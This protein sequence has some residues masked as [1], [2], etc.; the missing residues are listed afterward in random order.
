MP[1]GFGCTTHG[2]PVRSGPAHDWQTAASQTCC[3]RQ[4][5]R[6]RAFLGSLRLVAPPQ[7][8][9]RFVLLTSD[10]IGRPSATACAGR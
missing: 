4:T 5:F 7:S 9:G 10:L 2:R 1:C 8:I 3:R 6:M